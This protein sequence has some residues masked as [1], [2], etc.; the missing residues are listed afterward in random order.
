MFLVFVEL[1]E[2][3][4]EVFQEKGFVDFFVLMHKT[5][6]NAHNRRKCFGKTLRQDTR[7]SQWIESA[8][9]IVGDGKILF[10]DDVLVYV[11][12][13]IYKQLEGAFSGKIFFRRR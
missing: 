12:H 8:L 5:V 6:A 2:V 13:G 10:A 11:E 1:R 7:F 4:A 9:Q 3:F